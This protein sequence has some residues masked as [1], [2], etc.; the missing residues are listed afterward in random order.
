MIGFPEI[1]MHGAVPWGGFG[2]NPMPK[3]L[4]QMWD[5]TGS[6]CEGGFP[7]S[8]GIY[9]DINKMIM[10]SLYSGRNKN[11]V[12]ALRE[13]VRSEFSEK[14]EDELTDM[15]LKMEEGLVRHRV[16]EDGV[17]RDYPPAEY[18]W[19]EE[20]RYVIEN[21]AYVDEVYATAVRINDKLPSYVQASWRWRLVYLRAVIDYELLHNDFRLS[22]QSE[23]CFK[24]LSR[25]YY[26]PEDGSAGDVTPPYRTKGRVV[27]TWQAG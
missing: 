27:Q 9:E 20:P 24:E 13:Y 26:A 14:Y 22:D 3:R 17:E 6:F 5:E 11:A 2:A 8:E 10:L 15:L 21:I 19:K 25:M 18:V 16:D 7:Y 23:K 4:Q 1:S 12:S